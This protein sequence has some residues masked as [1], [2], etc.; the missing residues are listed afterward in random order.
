MQFKRL[1]EPAG[2]LAR[3]GKQSFDESSRLS[4]VQ[5]DEVML[6]DHLLRGRPDVRNH[7]CGQRSPLKSSGALQ[8][9]LVLRS[10]PGNKAI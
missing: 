4:F 9:S 5:A 2:G 1:R 3:R 6:T 7:K 8:Q 10:N